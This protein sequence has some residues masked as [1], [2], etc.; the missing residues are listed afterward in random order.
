A[1][2]R[3]ASWVCGR[4]G[5][6]ARAPARPP[7]PRA[8]RGWRA[9]ASIPPRT[10]RSRRPPPAALRGSSHAAPALERRDDAVHSLLR[11]VG[12]RRGACAAVA[13]PGRSLRAGAA[14]YGSVRWGSKEGKGVEERRPRRNG[15]LSEGAWGAGGGSAPSHRA[16]GA[17][18]FQPVMGTLLLSLVPWALFV[19]W[20]PALLRQ[21][22]RIA[23]YAPPAEDAAPLVSIIVPA[24]N[25]A[26]NIAQC[27]ST[28][29][30]SAY[31]R[32]E[33][34]GV[35]DGSVDGTGDIARA[36]AERSDGAV[37]VIDGAPLPEGWFGKPWACG[38]GYRA[39]RGEVLLYVDAD[40]RQEPELIG[41]AV[42]ALE[43]ERA[44]LVTVLPRQRL[45]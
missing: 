8:G 1:P 39:S 40:A 15:R 35:D 37:Q 34:I 2:A 44:D 24:R 6:S 30:D 10:D 29:L 36:L 14:S 7:P 17:V 41:H 32:R 31:A 9:A 25:E 22:P 5:G 38:Q 4:S 42:G 26:H 20:T 19:L 45:R 16:G 11:F 43:A 23:A 18:S 27:V 21:R 12:N 3:R 33:I 28:L 13:G